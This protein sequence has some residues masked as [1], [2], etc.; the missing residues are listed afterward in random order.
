MEQND[1]PPP[2]D[3]ARPR[4]SSWGNTWR[5]NLAVDRRVAG[6]LVVLTV[7]V[8]GVRFSDGRMLLAIASGLGPDSPA[9]GFAPTQ[10]VWDSPLKV[11][12]LGLLPA[13]I[14]WIAVAFAALGML[15][16]LGLLARDRSPVLYLT[17]V[18]VALTPALKVSAQNLGVGD[19]LV[20]L[21][22]VLAVA[23]TDRRA[24]A[25]CLLALALWH[26]QQA[27][28]LFGTY[29]LFS[30]NYEPRA[31]FE[32]RTLWGAAGLAIGGVAFLLH[33]LLV[34]VDYYDRADYLLDNA[35]RLPLENLAVLPVS[36]FCVVFWLCLVRR[37]VP[38]TRLAAYAV[39]WMGVLV[40]AALPALLIP[41][42]QRWRSAE[43]EP[44]LRVP[45]LWVAL[46][47]LLP[48]HSWSGFDLF[49]WGDVLR[50]L[51]TYGLACL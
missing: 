38:E 50:D 46:S 10:Y 3:T 49:L 15:P 27:F 30:L 31:L 19:G 42:R 2:S 47:L 51:C 16:L 13:H 26:P 43:A 37:A 40:A 18:L 22:A 8:A 29:S 28:F 4:R 21:L 44:V 5:R 9:F 6:W 35:H 24:V 36:A 45:L 12:V 23:S 1:R 20:Y 32:R 48:V 39:V 34:R 7:A 17:L 11:F 25:G 14:V 33:R 41:F